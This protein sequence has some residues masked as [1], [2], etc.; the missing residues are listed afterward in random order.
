MLPVIGISLATDVSFLLLALELFH[1]HGHLRRP[2]FA[3]LARLRRGLALAQ[4]GRRDPWAPCL[5]RHL[6]HGQPVYVLAVDVLPV[7]IVILRSEHL[8][9]SRAR[10]TPL[11]RADSRRALR[12]GRAGAT[13]V[14]LTHHATGNELLRLIVPLEVLHPLGILG[15]RLLRFRPALRL[16]HLLVLLERRLLG[17]AKGEGGKLVGGH[18]TH[19]AG[20]DRGGIQSIR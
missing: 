4:H 11:R 5:G 2:R 19:R 3:L 10:S 20:L 18:R 12:S 1:E 14:A 9:R 16:E 13:R 8:G 15:G 17:A 7:D 6:L